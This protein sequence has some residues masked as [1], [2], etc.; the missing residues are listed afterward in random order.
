[1]KVETI[2]KEF[3]RLMGLGVPPSEALRLMQR[4][5]LSSRRRVLREANRRGKWFGIASRAGGGKPIGRAEAALLAADSA[6]GR[7][8]YGNCAVPPHWRRLFERA[9]VRS[10]V[11]AAQ[12]ARTVSASSKY[13]MP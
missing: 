9:F 5:R 10:A 8:P 7:D 3:C 1:M 13:G 4:S 12:T 6:V 11:Y 2:P